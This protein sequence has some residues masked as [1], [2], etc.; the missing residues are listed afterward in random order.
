MRHWQTQLI[1][2]L[3][4]PRVPMA[5]AAFFAV[6]LLFSITH[7]VSNFKRTHQAI[8]MTKTTMITA[9]PLALENLHLMGMYQAAPVRLPV[10]TL[11]FILEGT[12]VFQDD[13]TRS[14]AIISSTG[15]SAKIYKTNDA[16]MSGVTIKKIEKDSIIV[17]DNGTPEK[18]LLPIKSLLANEG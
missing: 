1:P 4:D 13:P 8:V 2:W 3:R 5:L 6:I 15:K 14:R 10:S 9:A 12:I 17:D 18:I 11:Q 7:F 16:L